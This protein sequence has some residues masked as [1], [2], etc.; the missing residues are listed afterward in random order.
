MKLD[1]VMSDLFHADK[2]QRRQILKETMY[3][4]KWENM[5]EIERKSKR[6]KAM[7][8]RGDTRKNK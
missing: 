5:R 8:H 1:D 6:E 3:K 2:A 7:V 4:I